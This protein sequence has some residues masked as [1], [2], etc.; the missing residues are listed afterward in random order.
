[1]LFCAYRGDDAIRSIVDVD[2][3]FQ[4]FDIGGTGVLS[5]PQVLRAN[6]KSFSKL[7]ML[8]LGI[9]RDIDLVQIDKSGAV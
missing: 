3:E 9:F 4:L 1:M 5:Y 2:T 8:L 6:V 7:R